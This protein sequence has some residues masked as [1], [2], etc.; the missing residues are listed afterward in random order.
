MTIS[1]NSNYVLEHPFLKAAIN[2][3]LSGEIKDLKFILDSLQEDMYH[4]M[5]PLC[6]K[7]YKA[8]K[9][10]N[11]PQV[12]QA[13]LEVSPPD[14]LNIHL[15]IPLPTVCK[16]V[17]MRLVK[18]KKSQT[19]VNYKGQLEFDFNEKRQLSRIAN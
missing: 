1:Q 19:V 12:E 2:A 14:R 5:L 8:N 15:P 16:V 6:A 11:Y 17:P 3:F 4:K 7:A 10:E 13:I 18:Q 9:K